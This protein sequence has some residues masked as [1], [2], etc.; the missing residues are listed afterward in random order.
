MDAGAR[1]EI[2][3]A[4]VTKSEETRTYVRESIALAEEYVARI[5]ANN[6]DPQ[7]WMTLQF[8]MREKLEALRDAYEE[9]RAKKGLGPEVG[10]A[11][12]SSSLV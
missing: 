5:N 2:E 6:R 4:L 9:K 11:R 10:I 8:E 7:V 12:A 3:E 1:A